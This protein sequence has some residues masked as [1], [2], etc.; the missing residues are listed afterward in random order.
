MADR[1]SE[2]VSAKRI[3][4][5]IAGNRLELLESGEAR[6]RALLELI[7]GA[8]QS[9]KILMY[10]FNPDEVGERVR[11]A[12][13]ETARRGVDV[14]LLID[15]Y[16]SAAGP[17]FFTGLDESGGEICVF[18]PAYGRRYLLRN[19]QKLAIADDRIAILGG[20]NIDD[21]YMED[22]GAAHWR[23]LWLRIEGPEAK[24]ASH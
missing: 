14:Q 21:T 1:A 24:P 22:H 2:A 8:E 20:A 10:M 11:D 13:I 12:L 17:D 23:D 15:G 18:N 4:A 16:G 6:L 9:I 7:G 19:H 5:E 3:H